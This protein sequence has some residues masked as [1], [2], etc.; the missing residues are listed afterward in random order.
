M[1]VIAINGIVSMADFTPVT[2]AALG[3]IVGGV[4]GP[5][6]TNFCTYELLNAFIST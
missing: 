3:P 4:V 1:Q 5:L 6:F 2:V